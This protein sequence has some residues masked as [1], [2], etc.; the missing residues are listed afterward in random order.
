MDMKYRQ[1]INVGITDNWRYYAKLKGKGDVD[2]DGSLTVLRVY[3][4]TTVYH[5]QKQQ[6]M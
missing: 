2:D 1:I 3:L 4:N 5:H 6:S